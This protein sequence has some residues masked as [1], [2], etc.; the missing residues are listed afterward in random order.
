MPTPVLM[1]ALLPDM[2]QGKLAKWLVQEGDKI[3]LGDVIAHIDTDIVTME[4][5][6]VDE[7]TVGRILIAEGTEGVAVDTPIAMLFKEGEDP[8]KFKNPANSPGS[9]A[10]GNIG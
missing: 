4:L 3:A 9:A 5:M 1:P 8:S 7:G 10:E 2:E 6:A